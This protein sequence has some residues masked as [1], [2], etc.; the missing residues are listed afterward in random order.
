MDPYRT[1]HLSIDVIR[2]RFSVEE[3]D[4]FSYAL[5]DRFGDV[6]RR[7]CVIRFQAVTGPACMFVYMATSVW[8]VLGHGCLYLYL[9]NY[10]KLSPSYAFVNPDMISP[11]HPGIGA[12]VFFKGFNE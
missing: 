4:P 10:E 7:L 11:I 1:L 8:A 9:L 5:C 12:S 2:A 3:S 6:Y